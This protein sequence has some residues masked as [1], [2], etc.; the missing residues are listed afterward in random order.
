MILFIH[1]I[2]P[3]TIATREIIEEDKKQDEGTPLDETPVKSTNAKAT[4]AIVP[5]VRA[6]IAAPKQ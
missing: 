6:D 1:R 3:R 2:Y 5:D 4:Q